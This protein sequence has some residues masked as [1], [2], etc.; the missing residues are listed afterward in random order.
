MKDPIPMFW[1]LVEQLK[2]RHP[3]LAYI[4]VIASGAIFSKGPEDPSV[5]HQ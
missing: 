4:H 1:H 2:A 5:C 3:D